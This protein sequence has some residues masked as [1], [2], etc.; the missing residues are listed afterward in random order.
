[1]GRCYF[2]AGGSRLLP[3][4][5]GLKTF[6]AF[7]FVTLKCRLEMVDVFRRLKRHAVYSTWS[8]YKPIGEKLS[9][10]FDQKYDFVVLV[11]KCNFIVLIE[12]CIL[13]ILRINYNFTVLT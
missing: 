10:L 6:S 7:D 5:S 1:M 12:K 11:E 2:F 8:V 9:F 4:S 13:Q 3:D